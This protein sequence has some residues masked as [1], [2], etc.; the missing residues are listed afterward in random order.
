MRKQGRIR[1]SVYYIIARIIRFGDDIS[2][3]LQETNLI[4]R[5]IKDL[6]MIFENQVLF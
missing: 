4:K 1:E 5:L 3:L 2:H 6:Q